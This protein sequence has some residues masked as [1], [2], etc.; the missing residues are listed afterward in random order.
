MSLVGCP[1]FCVCIDCSV[2]TARRHQ[3]AD[4]ACGRAWVCQCGACNCARGCSDIEAR[5]ERL[6][7]M[8]RRHALLTRAVQPKG[9]ADA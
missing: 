2:A 1:R 7:S 6:K 8:E 3:E 9:S 4:A 5:I